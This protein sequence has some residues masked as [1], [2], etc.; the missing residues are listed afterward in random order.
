MMRLWRKCEALQCRHLP[1]PHLIISTEDY[2]TTKILS[3]PMVIATLDKRYKNG[4]VFTGVVKI[5]GSKKHGAYGKVLTYSK[6][7]WR[8]QLRVDNVWSTIVLLYLQQWMQGNDDKGKDTMIV[9]MVVGGIPIQHP[10]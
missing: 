9:M 5:V 3:E 10:T 2:S 8:Q 7:A 1:Q 4:A 6:R